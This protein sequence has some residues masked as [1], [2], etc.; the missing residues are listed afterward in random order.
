MGG[1]FSKHN[2]IDSGGLLLE[3]V[4]LKSKQKVERFFLKIKELILTISFSGAE[5]M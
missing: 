4:T 2:K 5:I 1:I 3:V